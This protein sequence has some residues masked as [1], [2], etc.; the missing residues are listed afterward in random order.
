MQ[1]KPVLRQLEPQT[2]PRI[3]SEEIPRQKMKH[4]QQPCRK[5]HQTRIMGKAARKVEHAPQSDQK[6]TDCDAQ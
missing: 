4:Q 1:F 3:E 5:G 6:C 2:V